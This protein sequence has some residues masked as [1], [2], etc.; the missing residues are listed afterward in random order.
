MKVSKYNEVRKPKNKID[1]WNIVTFIKV[2]FE[3]TKFALVF[4]EEKFSAKKTNRVR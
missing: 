4:P 3:K 1:E 2:L